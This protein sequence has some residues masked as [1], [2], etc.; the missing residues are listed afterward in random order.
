M[1]LEQLAAFLVPERDSLGLGRSLGQ[2]K[3]E[4]GCHAACQIVAGFGTYTNLLMVQA[5]T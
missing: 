2:A 4:S 1:L 3:H 5:A